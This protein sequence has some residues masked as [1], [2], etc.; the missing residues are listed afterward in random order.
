MQKSEKGYGD[1]VFV[2]KLVLFQEICRMHPIQQ[3]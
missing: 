1:I 3:G 2:P